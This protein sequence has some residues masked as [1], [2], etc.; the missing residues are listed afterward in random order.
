ME[1]FIQRYRAGE[2]AAE[3][4]DDFIDQWHQDDSFAPL[5]VFLGMTTAE[6]AAWLENP[7]TLG[8]AQPQS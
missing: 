7:Q 1:T 8:L 4:I 6:Y 3:A 2:I 5:S